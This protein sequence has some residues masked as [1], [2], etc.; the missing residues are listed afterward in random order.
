MSV[1]EILSLVASF[2]ALYFSWRSSRLQKLVNKHELKLKEYEEQKMEY[3]KVVANHIQ[4]ELKK[5]SNGYYYLHVMNHSLKDVY[6]V[7][8]FIPDDANCPIVD[9][10]QILPF[11]RLS[12]GDSFDCF[13]AVV[14]RSKPKFEIIINWQDVNG[15]AYEKKQF[16]S[17]SLSML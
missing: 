7:S 13:C 14:L 10:N 16:I 9:N 12:S 15:I 11:D 4:V 5:S 3:D 8:L 6:N 2:V 1:F 17:R